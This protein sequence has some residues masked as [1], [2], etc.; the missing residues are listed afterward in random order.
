MRDLMNM[1]VLALFAFFVLAMTAS[2]Y[3]AMT[4]YPQ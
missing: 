2:A 3:A 4:S 1:A